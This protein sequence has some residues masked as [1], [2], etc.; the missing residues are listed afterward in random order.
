M[1]YDQEMKNYPICFETADFLALKAFL[2]E[3]QYP[4]IFVLV[5]TN[6]KAA[7]FPILEAALAA[8]YPLQLIEIPAGEEHKNIETCSL[9]WSALLKGQA[10]RK[11][12][13]LNL[14]GGVIGDMGG[15][16]AATYKRGM[17]FIQ[18]PTTLLSEVDASV[19][20]KLGI[21]F[22]AV[23]NGVGVFQNPQMVLIHPPFLKTL[24]KRELYSGFAEVI[25]HAL[26]QD[27]EHWEKIQT[28]TALEQ[29]EDWTAIIDH[30]IKIKAKV[31]EQDPHEKGLRK[32][33]NF[34]HTIGHAI[35]SLSWETDQPLL[36][37]EA[38][39]IGM[40]CEAYIAQLELGLPKAE[41]DAI[42][43]YILK[44]YPP[45]DL[46]KLDRQKLLQLMLQDKK[47]EGASI[48]GSLITAIGTAAFNVGLKEQ[49]ILD[50]LNYYAF[51]QTDYLL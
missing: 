9:I 2:Q 35:E 38:I 17:D 16:C 36:H 26:I 37:G 39:A 23:K 5:D 49:M 33:L 4:S 22:Q 46:E 31:V 24:P 51:L 47:N 19:G 14:G 34:G 45:F 1:K 27:A 29:Y 48:L 7:C 21:D 15:F 42:A 28:I 43:N 12:L 3:K 18:I 44:L 8:E 32:I 11:S 25:K 41:L 6:T 30:S 13:L 20:G 10:S 40:I 50:S